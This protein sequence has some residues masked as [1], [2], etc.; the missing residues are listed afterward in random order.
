MKN[1]F[2]I[3]LVIC[4]PDYNFGQ[5][6]YASKQKKS[7]TKHLDQLLYTKGHLSLRITGTA[8]KQTYQHTFGKFHLQDYTKPGVNVTLD[9]IFNFDKN[10]GIRTGIIFGVLP[11]SV[12]YWLYDAPPT[13][14]GCQSSYGSE[15]INDYTYL[16]V[17]LELIY[18]IPITQKILL[19]LRAGG[20]IRKNIVTNLEGGY[21]TYYEEDGIEIY[22][23]IQEYNPKPYQIHPTLTAGIGASFLLNHYDFLN[24][25]LV[26]NLGLVDALDRGRYTFY[27]NDPAY[28]S[29]GTYKMK[30][31][32]RLRTE[33][34]L[35]WCT[36]IT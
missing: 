17:P 11:A 16:A 21:G 31:S 6:E 20:T 29:E 7:E 1:I 36:A 8:T 2:L 27:P 15:A 13:C 35:Y 5:V 32:Y 3:L 14:Q 10:W 9:Y 30:G 33:L 26:G 23:S 34:Y 4:F 25:H 18:R 28:R 24:V 22:T 19:N 12:K